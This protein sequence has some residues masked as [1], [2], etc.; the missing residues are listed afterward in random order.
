MAIMS[1]WSRI[2]RKKF[3]I[4][5]TSMDHLSHFSSKALCSFIFLNS[6]FIAM[7]DSIS[8]YLATTLSSNKVLLTADLIFLSNEITSSTLFNGD[9]IGVSFIDYYSTLTFENEKHDT[10]IKDLK[11]LLIKIK[12]RRLIYISFQ[13]GMGQRDDQI[14]SE[15]KKSVPR[16]EFKLITNYKDLRFIESELCS[17]VT[18]RYHLALIALLL[19]KEILIID[20]EIKFKALSK[21]FG[22]RSVDLDNLNGF[23]PDQMSYP[24]Q[25]SFLSSK[26]QATKNFAWLQ[27]DDFDSTSVISPQRGRGCA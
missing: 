22:V 9:A 3:I 20:H 4:L 7:R 26:E 25:F 19:K 12:E 16:L 1:L 17:V 27:P 6:D 11:N 8:W 14:F 13:N 18:M 2:R 15:L 23:E 5:G 21:D 10:F 24:E